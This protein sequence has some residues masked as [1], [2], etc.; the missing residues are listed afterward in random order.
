M[1]D[2]SR[3]GVRLWSEDNYGKHK[4]KALTKVWR[5]MSTMGELPSAMSAPCLGDHGHVT[6]IGSWTLRSGKYPTGFADA[7]HRYFRTVECNS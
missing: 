1:V 4:G 2:G 5:L 7:F 3:Q 6:T